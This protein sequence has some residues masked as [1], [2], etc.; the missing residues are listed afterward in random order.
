MCWFS[1]GHRQ[2]L[3]LL[4]SGVTFPNTLLHRST[5]VLGP[6]PIP[7]LFPGVEDFT[8][9]YLLRPQWVSTIAPAGVLLV[10]HLTECSVVF[11]HRRDRGQGSG[12]VCS[13]LTGAAV[14]LS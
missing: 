8:F 10:L 9:S 4:V 7:D 6:E 11:P 1:L 2:A 13:S 14:S 5:V 12:W 3:C